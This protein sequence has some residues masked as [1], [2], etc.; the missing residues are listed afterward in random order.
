MR[1]RISIIGA[2]S[3]AGSF[4]PGQEGAPA[5]IR[6]AGLVASLERAGHEVSDLG[7]TR[8]FRWQPDRTQPRAQNA[9]R[10]R[11]TIDE[12]S[13][14]VLASRA[15]GRLALVL[16]GDCTIELGTVAGI[17]RDGVRVGLVYFDMHADMNTPDGA[18][19]GALDWMGVAHMLDLPGSLPMLS[20]AGGSGPMLQPEQ[21]LILGHR[22]DQATEFERRDLRRLGVKTIPI[23][24]VGAAPG[25]SARA[26]L[27]YFQDSADLILVHFDVDVIDF[28]DAPLSENTGRNIG[29]TQQ[30]AFEVLEVL[31]SHP[32][33]AALTVTELNPNH[34]AE[35]GST[36][37][38]FTNCLAGA[39]GVI[40]NRKA[41]AG[42]PQA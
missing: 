3:S 20:R 26:A 27:D 37:K 15:A 22:D 12:V 18:P 7:D 31:L 1:R 29:L 11:A 19:P 6:A 8:A 35:D 25:D 9:E 33:I 28:T 14:R 24:E 23:A 32:C 17:G 5:A 34:G 40:D 38:D 4:A 36:V 42:N 30:A 2:P 21:V 13:T 41:L 16:G 39:F 10:V